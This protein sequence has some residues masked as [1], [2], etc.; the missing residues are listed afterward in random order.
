[1]SGEMIAIVAVGRNAGARIGTL[2]PAASLVFL[3]VVREWAER[4]GRKYERGE[5]SQAAQTD[6]IARGHQRTGPVGLPLL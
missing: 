3:G 2:A 1:M 5:C 4:I 6:R